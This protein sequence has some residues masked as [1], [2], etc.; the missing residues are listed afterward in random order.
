MREH[1][2]LVKLMTAIQ[3]PSAGS[4]QAVSV[5]WAG[6]ICFLL[7]KLL[8]VGLPPVM[9]G[10]P[11]LGDD[12]LAHLW[13]G[14]LV[15]EVGLRTAVSGDVSK[16]PLLVADIRSGCGIYGVVPKTETE[17]WCRRIMSRIGDPVLTSAAHFPM[18]VL[19]DLPLASKWQYFLFEIAIVCVLALGAGSLMRRLFGPGPAGLGLILLGPLILP[20]AQGM[21]QFVPST[22][23]I[24]L[25]AW[26]W[27]FALKDIQ[28][29]PRLGLSL[30]ISVLLA[31]IHPVALV[32]SAGL[33]LIAFIVNYRKLL[34][35]RWISF[36]LALLGLLIALVMNVD[37]LRLTFQLFLSQPFWLDI[38]KNLAGSGAFAMAMYRG[39]ILVYGLILLA[40]LSG[41]WWQDPRLR[42]T[43]LALL[44][45]LVLSLVH[46]TGPDI[47][48]FP[49]DLFS[50][51]FTLFTAIGCA[52]IGWF[53]WGSWSLKR[54]VTPIIVIVLLIAFTALSVPASLQN[55]LDNINGRRAL[56]NE[57]ALRE[58][59]QR[60]PAET[61]LVFGESDIT[62]P[63]VLLNGG[64][65]FHGVALQAVNMEAG[66][67]ALNR[68]GS[69]IVLPLFD[70]LNQVSWLHKS[71]FSPRLYSI[72][73][74]YSD[75]FSISTAK[76]ESR[77][78]YL[79]VRNRVRQEIDFGS[80]EIFTRDGQAA[81]LSLPK[82]PPLT[83]AWVAIPMAD[84]LPVT[85][86][87]ITLPKKLII[88]GVAF[89]DPADNMRWPWN[90]GVELLWHHRGSETAD[91]NFQLDLSVAGLMRS[92]EASPALI[93]AIPSQLSVLSD[94][95]GLMIA[96]VPAQY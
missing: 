54:P 62:I 53:L 15:Q 81:A 38:A 35:L 74:R 41:K 58:E 90:Q 40:L 22:L 44:V 55:T 56:I 4:K 91:N 33:M 23:T 72:D 6:F 7:C 76:G 24:S 42:G 73:G 9:M 20:G 25:S 18:A 34:T 46:S 59:L 39:N 29:G 88:T 70:E 1:F 10:L 60:L 61:T 2:K 89:G 45:L 50:R 37:V 30:L 47:F 85:R 21:Q 82:I 51:I 49:L 32:F 5:Y 83:D 92:T 19:T 64:G 78:L 93:D 43:I 11:R 28:S 26:L 84:K 67:A 71:E 65:R 48:F 36:G 57:V 79:R 95:S 8:L 17:A 80:A 27:S 66:K 52:L 87:T 31:T 77:Q 14:A 96:R 3:I 75:R 63:E 16:L 69:T 94:A 68:P 86:W 12:A 13:R